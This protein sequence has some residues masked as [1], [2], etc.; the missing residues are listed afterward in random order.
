VV[1]GKFDIP[2]ES[3]GGSQ[4][5]DLKFDLQLLDLNEG[6]D[7]NA[8]ENTKPL[9][10]LM[11]KLQGLGL[12]GLGGIAGGGSSN[13]SGSSSGTSQENLQKYSECI[14]KANGDTSKMQKCADLLTP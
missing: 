13:G 14:Q 11:G 2:N 3:G 1:A 9:S 4:S 6:Q 8:P 7:I 5:A 12:G 10:E